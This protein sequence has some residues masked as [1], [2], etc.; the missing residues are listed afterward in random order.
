M[1]VAATW[2]TERVERVGRQTWKSGQFVLDNAYVAG[3]FPIAASDFGLS[4]LDDFEVSGG[5]VAGTAGTT[6]L[7]PVYDKAAGKISLFEGGATAN[8]NPFDETDISDTG[9]YI[10]RGTAKGA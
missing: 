5:S 8:D 9:T 2:T 10:V 7:L 3:G 4:R 1:T 6:G